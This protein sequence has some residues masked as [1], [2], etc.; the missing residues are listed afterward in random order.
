MSKD[1]HQAQLIKI[2]L[3]AYSGELA[4]AYAYRG[5]WKSVKASFEIKGIKKI[6]NEEWIHR[7]HVGEMLKKLGRQPSRFKEIKMWIIGRTIGFLC[8]FGSWFFPMYFAGRLEHGNVKEYDTAA[9]HAGKVGLKKFQKQLVKM[10][11]TEQEHEDFFG[12]MVT[13]HPLLPFT[14]SLFTWGP[15]EKK[16]VLV[17]KPS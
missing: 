2:L 11:K 8:H 1:I 7:A 4:A 6:E 5:H 16:P 13:D 14:Q 12:A 15:P 17:R 9:F 10:A 3:L